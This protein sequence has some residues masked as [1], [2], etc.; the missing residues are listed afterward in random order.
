MLM[1]SLQCLT[2]H[3]F[4]DD[5]V[6]AALDGRLWGGLQE[7]AHGGCESLLLQLAKVRL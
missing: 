7:V 3:L 5:V 6:A 4:V 1:N 2:L